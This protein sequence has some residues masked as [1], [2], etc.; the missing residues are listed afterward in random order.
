MQVRPLA[1]LGILALCVQCSSAPASQQPA[2]PPTVEQREELV[3]KQV[4]RA[5][6]GRAEAESSS[7]SEKSAAVEELDPPSPVPKPRKEPSK[8][9]LRISPGLD[10]KAR[11]AGIK[12]L[13]HVPFKWPA[14]DSGP[15]KAGEPLV[16]PV[17]VPSPLPPPFPA[18]HVP[19]GGEAK[20]FYQQ[21]W[22]ITR[23]G[24]LEMADG[25]VDF[26]KWT[27]E[28]PS[29]A[30]LLTPPKE[31]EGIVVHNGTV[32]MAF[33]NQGLRNYREYQRRY[34]PWRMKRRDLPLHTEATTY[35]D[36]ETSLA[37]VMTG[38]IDADGTLELI[39]YTFVRWL[40]EK[41][42]PVRLE[43]EIGVVWRNAKKQPAVLSG[44]TSQPGAFTVPYAAP[45]R[46]NGGKP[47]VFSV[48]Y[49]CAT[50]TFRASNPNVGS[51]NNVRWEGEDGEWA[52]FL[53]PSA[54]REATVLIAAGVPVDWEAAMEEEDF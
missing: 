39:S 17:G 34:V 12:R 32:L 30:L 4:P 14:E 45:A 51:Y 8:K 41:K 26:G 16:L 19:S 31:W 53:E 20:F 6:P 54:T 38:D 37:T 43:G 27:T 2:T 5:E 7:E 15:R 11:K 44:F 25:V 52:V 33:G 9:A 18:D 1:V 29:G 10:D 42:K 46:L 35:S 49:C 28:D 13:T 23:A 22:T 40:D 47:L 3:P 36:I 24:V 21:Q 48:E 50:T